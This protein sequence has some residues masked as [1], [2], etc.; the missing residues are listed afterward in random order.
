MTT[1]PLANLTVQQ[2]KRAVAIR[3]KIEGLEKD[4]NR[5]V[6]GPSSAPKNAAP[7]KRRK[8]SPAARA[9]IS[10]AMKARWAKIRARK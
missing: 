10:R 3:E 1:N 7:A 6:G 8:L 9:R 2:L 4:L 5:I